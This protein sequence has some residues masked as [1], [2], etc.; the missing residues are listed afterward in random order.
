MSSAP[1]SHRGIMAQPAFRRF[2]A[3]RTLSLVG[4]YAFRI[5]FATHLITVTGS[6]SVLAAATAALLVPS[7]LFYLVGGAVG[8]RTKARRRV[9]VVCD[10]ARVVVLLLIAAATYWTTSALL[11]VALSLLIGIA[12]GF[13][14]P[15]S[16]SYML[17]ITSRDK[18]VSANSAL[19]V[20]M[21]FG[22]IGGPLIGG[23]LVGFIG[24][25]AT[26]AFDALTFLLSGILLM[27][28]PKGVTGA[29]PVT[30][31]EAADEPRQPMGEQ[32]RRFG[33][34]I[35]EALHYVRGVPWLLIF[36]GVGALVNAVFAGVL[37]VPIPLI[38]SPEGTSQAQSLGVFYAL[39]GVGALIG[40]VILMRLT[41]KRLGTSMFAM[42]LMMAAAL[43]AV[44]FFG[45]GIPALAL[46]LLYGIG[47]HVFNSLY[48]SLLQDRVPEN[49]T[50]RVGSLSFLGFDGLIPLG[51]LL[52]GPLVTTMDARGAAV[53]AGAAA[54]LLSLAAL[55]APSIRGLKAEPPADV[56][57]AEPDLAP[58]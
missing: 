3:A 43:T 2:W 24:A 20:S 14:M 39:E 1:Q 23:L 45:G 48:P 50:S 26:F 56:P 28:R 35:V 47:L 8:D 17:E 51:T 31:G 42:L 41:V 52:M 21:Q 25:P 55:L 12:D 9:L 44:G 32:L 5:A 27:V 46:A 37:D 57:A 38:M 10:V 19:S 4:D 7:L 34:D 13:F 6:A 40:A 22:L 29:R 15:V 53:V 16:F 11:L 30:T 36:L 54:V 58:R 33:R 18:L 49:L